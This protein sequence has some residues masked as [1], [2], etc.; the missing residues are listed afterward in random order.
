MGTTYLFKTTKTLPGQTIQLRHRGIWL[1]KG[2]Q[3]VIM[4]QLTRARGLLSSTIAAIS[5]GP[6]NSDNNHAGTYFVTGLS[7]GEWLQVMAKLELTYH[8]LTNDFTLKLGV[9]GQSKEGTLGYVTSDIVPIGTPGS[10]VDSDGDN[11]RFG[12]HTVHISKKKMLE[13]HEIGVI[14]LIHEC[15]HKFASTDDYD[16][17]G[18]RNNAD[19]GWQAPGLTH[20]EAMNNA[21]SYAYLAYHMG[22]SRGW[23]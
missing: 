17:R 2:E 9:R 22:R 10:F 23:N 7:S 16:P 11:V 12:S 14:T 20:A 5:S 8:G 3:K 21:D 18:Y 13:D 1:A 6:S 15:T 4:S 19:T